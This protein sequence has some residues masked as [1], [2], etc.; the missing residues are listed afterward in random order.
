M[1]TI[2]IKGVNYDTGVSSVLSDSTNSDL[3]IWKM[4][5]EI[6]IIKND[7]HCN[8]IRIYG[9]DLKKLV[10]CANIAIE[11]GLI[12]WFSPRFIN[13]SPE[14]MLDYINKCSVAA[15]QLRK[16]SSDLVYVLGNEFSLDIKGF[17]EGETMQ[18]RI[19]KFSD[20]VYRIKNIFG[21]EINKKLNDFLKKSV[22]IA[23]QDFKGEITYASGQWEKI[24]WDLFDIVSINYYR[25][26]YNFLHYK[27][28]IKK[29]VQTG[30][31]FAITEF[32]C[33][34]YQGADKKGA[35]GY[36]VVNWKTPK[37]SL[38]KNYKRDES[39]QSKYIIELLEIFKHE[40]VWAVFVYT[41]VARKS[42]YNVNPKFDLDMA[43]FGL[44]KVLSNNDKKSEVPYL[45]ESKKAFHEL[46]EFYS[47]N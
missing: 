26:I 20:P 12:V 22:S 17:I 21:L 45:W 34:C 40:N 28:K 29:L 2:V 30:K 37:P 31:K 24:N 27:R 33:C 11:T 14:E 43:N 41:F 5:E 16:I 18:K 15:E 32:G 23:R 42:V 13:V 8:A 9:R 19:L 44:I 46:S 47:D 35:L 3:T 38:I 6:G 1:N 10:E 25:N 39:V 36:L 4:K 7:L